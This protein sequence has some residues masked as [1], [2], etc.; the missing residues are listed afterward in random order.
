[1]FIWL[2]WSCR[3][4]FTLI[5]RHGGLFGTAPYLHYFGGGRTELLDQD[6]DIWSYFDTVA[7]VKG[8]GYKEFKLWWVTAEDGERHVFRDYKTDADALEF[9]KYA[10]TLGQG[11]LFVENLSQEQPSVGNVPTIAMLPS[12][13]TVSAQNNKVPA[14]NNKVSA[15]MNKVLP[16]KMKCVRRSSRIQ[17]VVTRAKYLGKPSLVVLSDDDEMEVELPVNVNTSPDN[18]V[19]QVDVAPENISPEN[20]NVPGTEQVPEVDVVVGPEN[21]SPDNNVP[22][23]ID[24]DGENSDSDVSVQRERLQD[25]DEERDLGHEDV[26]DNTSFAE[27]E[28]LLNEHIKQMLSSRSEEG[29]GLAFG[30]ESDSEGGYES[31]DLESVPTDSEVEDVPRRRF[32]KFVKEKMGQDFKFSLGMDFSSLLQFKDA[33]HDHFVTNGR[34]FEYMKNDSIRCRVKCRSKGCPFVILC[35]KVGNKETFRIKT[36]VGEH[37]CARVFDNKSANVRWVKLKLLNKVSTMNKISTNE[38][39]DDFRFN[40]GTGITRYRAWKGKQL[41]IQEVEGAIEMQYTLLWRF[42]NE[43]RKRA[44]GNTCKINFES[45]RSTLF[46]RFS[47][48]YMCLDGCKRGFLAGCRPFIGLD[49]CHLKTKHRGILLAA[50]AR[51]ANEQYFPLA[52]GVVE[53]ETKDSWMWFMELLM[54][55]IDPERSRRWVF[56]SDQQKGLMEVF[57]E[58]MLHGSEHRLCVRHLYANMKTKFGGGVLLRDLMMGA[59]KA[60]YEAAWKEKMLLIKDANDSAY[61][62]LMEKPT[63][64]WCRHA[65]SLYSRCDVVMNN[66]SEAFNAAIMLARDKPILTM[67]EWIRTY[68]MGRFPQMMEKLHKHHGQIMPRPLKRI[69]HEVDHIKNWIPRV[70]G[71][72]KYEV[73]HTITLERHV[74]SLKDKSCTCRFWELNGFP[75]RHAASALTFNGND[76]KQFVDDCYKRE[77]YN[78]TYENYVTPLPGPN[79]WIVTP[80]DPV[81]ILPPMYKRSAGRPKKLRRRDPY[82]NDPNPTKL[83]RG[84]ATWK[85]SRCKQYGHNKRGCKNPVPEEQSE[86]V[87]EVDEAVPGETQATTAQDDGVQPSTAQD[88]GVQPTTAQK[89]PKNKGFKKCSRCKQYGH[90]KTRCKNIPE[91]I[92]MPQP[93]SLPGIVIREPVNPNVTASLP[94]NS[95]KMKEKVVEDP[96]SVD[97]N[98]HKI[99]AGTHGGATTSYVM[100]GNQ[101]GA[102]TSGSVLQVQMEIETSSTVERVATEIPEATRDQVIEDGETLPTQCSVVLDTA[103]GEST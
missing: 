74:I 45:P 38:I 4:V 65:F 5:V 95:G 63:S 76:P 62:W 8:M 31:E 7:I 9:A 27:A 1:M 35:S 78:A 77:A 103:M 55:D 26:L 97:E 11:L 59:A 101:G 23:V 10:S 58:D 19:P 13:P 86:V 61:Q 53:S 32:P 89:K 34:E 70:V 72:Q 30:D 99:Y 43:L 80:H 6:E 44:A 29:M 52:F 56:I 28:A 91:L 88:D 2:L 17:A 49:G 20:D 21:I 39:V 46:P 40:H 75:C 96:R 3:M 67:M 51:D 93:R 54:D 12:V 71:A 50:V 82:E 100:T 102:S 92:V 15:Q 73:R 90:Y 37:N 24:G 57:K 84:G 25:S 36:L 16:T 22:E 42:S 66:L 18:N 83:Q 64:S 79:Q 41:A 98:W 48:F 69:L 68:V 14:Q 87:P 60:T 94:L 81:C 47:R 33:L 85:C